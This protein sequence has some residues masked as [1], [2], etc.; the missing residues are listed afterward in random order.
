VPPAALVAAQ[1][2]TG[3]AQ[4][5]TRDGDVAYELP[6]QV[7]PAQEAPAKP[8][9]VQNMRALV[10]TQRRNYEEARAAREAAEARKLERILHEQ[11]LLAAERARWDEVAPGFA[12][13]RTDNQVRINSQVCERRDLLEARIRENVT[14]YT[15]TKG[16]SKSKRKLSVG[17]AVVGG[18]LFGAPGAVAGALL[19]K[20]EGDSHYEAVEELVCDFVAV[21]VITRGFVST[22]VLLNGKVPMASERYT[23]AHIQALEVERRVNLIKAQF[24]RA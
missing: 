18:V 11:E 20:S 21:D 16:H 22:V 6:A 9:L 13:S 19:G 23:Q 12:L 8:T 10:A 14:S 3:E 15:R 1:T 24:P 4:D 2:P 17:K 7:E 5:G